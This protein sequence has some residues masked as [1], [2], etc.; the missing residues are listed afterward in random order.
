MIPV[1]DSLVSLNIKKANQTGLKYWSTS[2]GIIINNSTTKWKYSFNNEAGSTI[3]PLDYKTGYY[4]FGTEDKSIVK[5][6]YV[7]IFSTT[8]TQ[9]TLDLIN[10]SILP[11]QDYEQTEHIVINPGDFNAGGFARVRI[12]PKYARSLGTSLRIKS[13]EKILIYKITAEVETGETANITA[14]RTV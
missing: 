9:T 7:T 5:S 6:F 2:S 3:V 4:G 10:Y 14:Q 1:R 12:I 13:N 11:D 8:K